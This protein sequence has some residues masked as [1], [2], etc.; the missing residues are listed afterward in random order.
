MAINVFRLDFWL[1]KIFD[2]T[3]STDPAIA[4]KVGK[5]S[6]PDQVTLDYLKSANIYH[7]HAAR[8][9]VP[10]QWHVTGELLDQC[11]DL[12]CIST[13][14]AGYDPVDVD[15][16]T[17]RGILVVNQSGG[18]ADSVAEH[19]LSLMLDVKHRI[20]ESDRVM[21]AHQ[22]GARE[23]LMGNEIRG[24]TLGLVGIGQIGAKVAAL[25]KAFGMQVI[26][27]DPYLSMDE[28]GLRGA[29]QVTFDELLANSDIISL[30]CPRNAETLN[31][32]DD[33]AFACMKKGSTFISTARG[34]IHN[35]RDLY[36]A[37]KSGKLSGS[38]LDVWAVE[39][40]EKN[41]LLLTLPNVV[42]TYHTAGV[43]HEA[44]YNGA[45]LAADQIQG[46]VRGEKP[47]R[48]INPEVWPLVKEKLHKLSVVA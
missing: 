43:T 27:Y 18:N 1:N 42:A 24:L 5:H 20:T 25:A 48:M 37:L 39:P 46:F 34:G 16:C 19:A 14:G 11:P 17:K 31:L 26:A 15:A 3:M 10:T 45:K 28:V 36:N 38:G 8:D 12:I 35:E 30:H 7:I 9:E 40:P 6:D 32:F 4:L 22:C 21:R 33:K 47:P 13:S 41:N 2:E 29:S 23:D 44:R